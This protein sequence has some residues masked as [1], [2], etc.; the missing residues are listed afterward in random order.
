MNGDNG[1]GGH[2]VGRSGNPRRWTF[3]LNNPVGLVRGDPISWEGGEEAENPERIPIL[4]TEGKGFRYLIFQL[5]VGDNDTP[6][7]QGSSF[8]LKHI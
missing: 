3:T 4:L 6:H 5:E 7:Y 2:D 8:I 1:A